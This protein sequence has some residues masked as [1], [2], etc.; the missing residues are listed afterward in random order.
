M[1]KIILDLWRW[2]VISFHFFIVYE[3][4]SVSTWWIT[5][6]KSISSAK[7]LASQFAKDIKEVIESKGL[8]K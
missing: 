4:K 6:L 5:F 3:I 8:K 2:K 7:D 1:Y